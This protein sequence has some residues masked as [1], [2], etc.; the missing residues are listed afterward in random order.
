MPAAIGAVGSF[1]ATIGSSGFL[2]SVAGRLLTGVA[3]SA[4]SAALQPGINRPGVSVQSTTAGDTTPISIIFGRTGTSGNLAAPIYKSNSKWRT[5]VI[6]LA[7]HPIEGVTRTWVNGHLVDWVGDRPGVTHMKQNTPVPAAGA[8]SN[9]RANSGYRA[10]RGFCPL[11]GRFVRDN[12]AHFAATFFDGR[13]T[14]VS[15]LLMDRHGSESKRPWQTDMIGTG[16]A[17]IAQQAFVGGTKVDW[18]GGDPKTRHE[19]DGASLY[20]PRADAI[21]FT[22][23]PVVMVRAIARGIQLAD[24]RTWGG[25]VDPSALPA[26][27]W[28]EMMD[29]CDQQVDDGNGGTEPQFRAGHEVRVDTGLPGVSGDRPADAMEEILKAADGRFAE[30]ADRWLVHVGRPRAPVLS[31]TD[32]DLLVSRVETFA[33]GSDGDG[34]ITAVSVTYPDPETQ[35][36][37]KKSP[38]FIDAAL[39]AS[40]VQRNAVAPTLNACPY[41]AQAQRIARKMVADHQRDRVHTIGLSPSACGLE[42]FDTLVWTSEE[43]GYDAKRFEVQSVEMDDGTLAVIATIREV[44]PTDND[45]TAGDYLEPELSEIGPIA[46]IPQTVTGVSAEPF[47]ASNAADTRFAGGIRIT[48]DGDERW[49]QIS[50]NVRDKATQE[51][52]N[53]ALIIGGDADVDNYTVL[54]LVSD[55]DYEFEIFPLANGVQTISTGWI[56][57]RSADVKTTRADIA[58]EILASIED[59]ETNAAAA[60]QDAAEAKN[61]LDDFLVGYTGGAL[62]DALA[63]LASDADLQ[64]SED[65]LTAQIQGV[66]GTVSQ[67]AA[68]LAQVDGVVRAYSGLTAETVDVNGVTRIAGLRSFSFANPD[69]TGG[70]L[71]EFLG[72]NVIAEGTLSTNRLVVGLG[73]NLLRNANPKLN[74]TRFWDYLGSSTVGTQTE[75]LIKPAGQDHAGANYPTFWMQQ[76]GTGTTGQ[77]DVRSVDMSKTGSFDQRDISVVEGQWLIF[78]AYVAV[79]RCTGEMIISWRDNS[80]TFIESSRTSLPQNDLADPDN[81]ENWPRRLVKAQA[82]AGATFAQVFFRKFGP[83]ANQSPSGI[84]WHKPMVEEAHEAATAPSPWSPAGTSLIDGGNAFFSGSI[85][86]DALAANSVTAVNI[87]VTDLSAISANL[88]S[89]KVGTANIADVV[90]SANFVS[91]SAGTGWAVNQNGSA[92]FNDVTIRRR[93]EV[94]SGVLNIGSFDPTESG[95]GSVLSND[96]AS[97]G[98]GAFVDVTPVPI[99]S[100]R[101]DR[102]TYL[103]VANMTGSVNAAAN[104]TPDVY[105]GW[106]VRILPLT[107]W[108]GDQSLRLRLEFWSRNVTFVNNCE[109]QWTIYEVS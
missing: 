26:D 60:L 10:G 15:P 11:G 105:W 14:A 75:F 47:I 57:V 19:V 92:E 65:T 88:G 41:P 102:K 106:D 108:T 98:R 70:S 86:G 37:P 73:K 61:E 34:P 54:G 53:S 56:T 77:A 96:W 99:T 27:V 85:L 48:W 42:P 6:D 66:S 28:L 84:L 35:Y 12:K 107:R 93:I 91:G 38:L 51:I 78:S 52:V 58:T 2:S 13:Q 24:G 79:L 64:A 95:S 30:S 68:A 33:D 45:F 17:Y 20:D 63:N 74:D 9:S 40:G 103:A 4:L 18:L 71:L 7:D 36:E 97:R 29:V 59:A 5:Y 109:V 83:T 39:E 25:Q 46:I 72:D 87:D 94:A 23:N 43:H 49:D 16:V 89:I 67:Q 32:D 50:I 1:F 22:D 76:T 104:T 100:W 81:P 44:D 69:G 8:N 31:I 3:L 62:V 55:T 80:G 101:G 82:P 90:S 21:A